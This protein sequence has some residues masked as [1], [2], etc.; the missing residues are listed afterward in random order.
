MHH[1]AG[2]ST[3]PMAGDRFGGGLLECFVGEEPIAGVGEL[4]HR[5]A[6]QQSGLDEHRGSITETC[7]HR[8]DVGNPTGVAERQAGDLVESPPSGFAGQIADVVDA[9]RYDGF[10]PR[11]SA[12]PGLIPV[13]ITL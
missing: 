1:G 12:P 4:G 5:L 7:S 3:G 6:P 9:E 8:G 11:R 2:E 13:T 10:F